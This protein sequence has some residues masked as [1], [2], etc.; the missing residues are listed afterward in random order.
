M[1]A[2]IT[3]ALVL[4][5]S[6]VFTFTICRIIETWHNKDQEITNMKKLIITLMMIATMAMSAFAA[7]ITYAS[8]NEDGT[9]ITTVTKTKELPASIKYMLANAY[10]YGFNDG[11]ELIYNDEEKSFAII[12]PEVTECVRVCPTKD[13]LKDIAD[14]ATFLMK[15]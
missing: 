9:T 5:L 1:D 8:Y 6:M 3:I 11:V 15:R 13:E 12:N 4:G 2:I 7:E 10:V 14:I